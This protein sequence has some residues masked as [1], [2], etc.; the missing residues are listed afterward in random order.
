VFVCLIVGTEQS[1]MLY[2]ATN[3]LVQGQLK[4]RATQLAVRHFYSCM[5]F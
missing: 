1:D 4:S 5:G 3:V 2:T